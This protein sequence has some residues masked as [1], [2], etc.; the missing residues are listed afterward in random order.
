MVLGLT[1]GSGTGKS[2][3]CEYFKNKGFLVVDSDKIAREVCS[4]GERCLEEIRLAFGDGVIDEEGNLKRKELGN[5]VFADSEKLKLLNDIT[6]KYIVER[7]VNIIE[8]NRNKNIVLDAPLLFEAGLGDIC[9]KKIC[10]LSERKKRIE[11]IMKRDGLSADAAIARI[12]SQPD[13]EFYI[14]RCDY[15]VYNNSDE[16]KLKAML[17]NIFG[18]DNEK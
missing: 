10:V 12:S 7:N 2:T 4:K 3:A 18:G 6:H 15:V 8:E 16:Y 14:S 11:R 9:T 1:G 17:D 13:D 5:I